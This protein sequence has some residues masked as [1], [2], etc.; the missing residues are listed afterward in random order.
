MNDKDKQK[1][2]IKLFNNTSKLLEIKGE[3]PFKV[4]A[5]ANAAEILNSNEIVLNELVNDNKLSEI[6]GIGKALNDKILEFYE[7]GAIQF[8]SNLI[9]DYPESLLDLLKIPNI[10][11]K[12]V[13]KLY[14]NFDISNLNDLENAIQNNKLKAFKGFTAKTLEN[15][16]NSIH[17]IK[18]SRGKFLNNNI[19]AQTLNILEHLKQSK[20]VDKISHTGETRRFEEIYTV[21]EFVV[22]PN[23]RTKLIEELEASCQIQVAD[24]TITFINENEYPVNIYLTD[25]KSFHRTLLQT[26]GNIQFLDTMKEYATKQGINLEKISEN[27]EEEIFNK[28]NLQFVPPVLRNTSTIISKAIEKTIPRIVQYDDLKGMIHVH[29][30][31]SDGRNSIREIALE[32]KRLGFEYIAIC[33][34]SQSATYANGLTIDRVKAQHEEIDKLNE[35]KLGIRIIKGIESDILKDGSLDYP[36][37][38]LETFELVIASVHSNFNLPK[39]EMTR[40]IKYALMSPYSHILG[41]PTGRLLLVRPEYELDIEEVIQTATEYGKVIEINCNPYRL[42]LSSDNAS[43]AKQIGLKLAINPDSHKINTLTDVNY[44]ISTAQRALLEPDDIINCMN[45][46]HFLAYYKI[47]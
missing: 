15:I 45:L 46:E 6:K 38:V 21:I 42:D 44:G 25:N 27:S 22:V 35:E 11:P 41:H 39:N 28:L 34:H 36:D 33:D 23:N 5:Y 7:T 47:N 40:R 32:A 17:H 2:I 31:W 37:A 24:N 18:A 4:K 8:Y 3:N 1:E 30:N 10:G 29:S 16:L 20:Y 43:Y 26:T 9:K 12:T 14:S 19:P 13:N